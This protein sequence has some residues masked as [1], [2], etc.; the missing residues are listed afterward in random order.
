M[1]TLACSLALALAVAGCAC[2]N[3]PERVEPKLSS[4]QRLVLS[5][6]CAVGASCHASGGG[7]P[8]GHL[9][10]GSAADSFANLVG[11]DAYGPAAA[12]TADGGLVESPPGSGQFLTN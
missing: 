11:V 3:P 12:H 1:R 10:L 2:E 6:S 5:P 9:A 4:I 8:A 7:T